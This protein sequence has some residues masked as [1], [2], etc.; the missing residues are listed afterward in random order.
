MFSDADAA[1]VYDLLNPWD[2][3]LSPGDRFYHELAMAADLV[4]GRVP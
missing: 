3:K 2:P 1:A 4:L